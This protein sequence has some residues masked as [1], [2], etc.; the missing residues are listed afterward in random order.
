MMAFAPRTVQCMP[1]LEP[2]AD[3]HFAAGLEDDSGGTETL[4]A[5][6]RATR[7]SAIVEDV[8]RAFGR[9]GTGSRVGAEG[10]DDGMQFAIIQ[11]RAARRGL[12][13]T[14]MW[15]WGSEITD[16]ISDLGPEFVDCPN[17]LTSDHV[18]GLLRLFA[19][20]ADGA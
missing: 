2:G 7:A 10:A 6:F 20:S 14:A 16:Y 4:G 3:H 13:R 15:Q 17:S 8:Q 18:N 5:K 9:L 12:L 11:F 19:D 1:A